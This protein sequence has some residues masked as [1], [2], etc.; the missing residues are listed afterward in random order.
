MSSLISK[1]R[2]KFQNFRR[3][4]LKEV[5]MSLSKYVVNLFIIPDY[6]KYHQYN[7]AYNYRIFYILNLVFCCRNEN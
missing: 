4:K 6:H 2:H 7:L 1:F 3:Y 5:S